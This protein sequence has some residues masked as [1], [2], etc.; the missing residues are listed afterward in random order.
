[1][2]NTFRIPLLNPSRWVNATAS[3]DPQ[4]N[5]KPFDD[6]I[7]PYG[8][9]IPWQKNGTIKIQ[10]YSDYPEMTGTIY[11]FSPYYDK[12][13]YGNFDL[14]PS[15]LVI[16]GVSFKVYEAEIPLADFPEDV[17][18]AEI[19]YDSNAQATIN[20]TLTEATTPTFIDAELQTAI[21]SIVVSEL[22]ASGS[23]TFTAASGS[24]YHFFGAPQGSNTGGSQRVVMQI[25]KDGVLIYQ[26]AIASTLPGGMIKTGII[27]PGSVY[28]GLCFSEDTGTVYP[29]I[30]IDDS[31]PVTAN[32]QV[33]RSCLWDVRTKQP[34]TLLYQYS[35]SVND[36]DIIFD[37]GIV[38]DLRLSAAINRYEPGSDD[39]QYEDQYYNVLNENSIPFRTF[40]NEIYAVGTGV[41]PDWLVDKLN[42]IYSLNQVQIDGQY[43]NKFKGE[44]FNLQRNIVGPNFNSIPSIKIIPS[45]NLN[46][47][48]FTTTSPTG[49]NDIQVIVKDQ[50]YD[51]QTASWQLA[52]E[53]TS[54]S[55]LVELSFINS[56]GDAFELKLGTTLG[57][58]DIGDYD[59]TT[60]LSQV[61]QIDHRF[62]TAATLYVTVPTGVNLTGV[63]LVWFQYDAAN[64]T[65]PDT[66][67]PWQFGTDYFYT[68]RA[69]DGFASAAD[70]LNAHWNLATGNGNPDTPY[71]GCKI[72]DVTINK[73]PII[74]NRSAYLADPT[75]STLQ[76]GADHGVSGN[77]VTIVKANLPNYD[78]N[79]DSAIRYKHGTAEN[80]GNPTNGLS[81]VDGG[82]GQF[83]IMLGGS[84]T[85]IDIT[86]DSYLQ[87]KFYRVS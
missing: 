82:R 37:T 61:I 21:D 15:D 51:S 74:W 78:L 44:T 85:P 35:N 8:Y 36:K 64:I 40:I 33:W 59:V 2:A 52:G 65:P 70:M 16:S 17:Y 48:K 84:S 86:P 77:T 5:T 30:D 6:Q 47:T 13:F 68:P 66:S 27:K 9:K 46:L 73:V 71:Y 24:E 11:K 79:T 58:T 22:T 49:D 45:D 26:K 81:S 19:T 83:Q 62:N 41:V 56:G 43:Y 42:L 20:A 76:P 80:G 53:F 34:N 7:D 67:S 55:K 38:F 23:Q 75:N 4:Y 28:E 54:W 25:K 18:Y 10:L 39:E 31:Q 1:M 50:R 87:I 60:D 3:Y 32:T 69:L 29:D 12:V 14:V 57:G 63:V 72:D